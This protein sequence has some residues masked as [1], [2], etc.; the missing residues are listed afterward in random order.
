MN[1]SEEELESFREQ[2]RAE[3]RARNP[4]SAAG[5]SSSTTSSGQPRR[6]GGPARKPPL[7][8]RKP[9]LADIDEEHVGRKSVDGSDAVV[10]G[11]EASQDRGQGST[12][13]GKQPVSALDHYEAAVEKETAGSLGDSL[14]LY[15]KAFRVCRGVDAACSAMGVAA[16][17][18]Y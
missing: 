16:A 7:P 14:K 6:P 9:L 5:P 1:P 18:L 15:R 8:A 13:K 4:A 10:A 3:V 11:A 12:S 17:Q 2:W